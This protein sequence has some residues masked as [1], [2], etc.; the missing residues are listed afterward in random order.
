MIKKILKII[1]KKYMSDSKDINDY[2]KTKTALKT[3]KDR[4]RKYQKKVIPELLEQGQDASEEQELLEKC[5]DM[6]NT[7]TSDYA[8]SE[9]NLIANPKFF[10]IPRINMKGKKKKKNT[11]NVT[12]KKITNKKK[13]VPKST[14]NSSSRHSSPVIG[15][16]RRYNIDYSDDSDSGSVSSS[17]KG[18]RKGI[19]KGQLTAIQPR[20]QGHMLI[21]KSKSSSKSRSR[22]NSNS[23]SN[24]I[25]F[26]Y[27]PPKGRLEFMDSLDRAKFKLLSE[28][29]YESY[30]KEIKEKRNDQSKKLANIKN[31]LNKINK[32]MLKNK[33][34]HENLD[35]ERIK[36]L[37]EKAKIEFEIEQLKKEY[38]E[39]NVY[40]RVN[41]MD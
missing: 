27:M 10:K 3:L 12:N 23:I 31:Q 2:P 18:T 14:S 39:K 22:S 26:G 40:E 20:K 29:D 37:I 36:L 7:I 34:S 19:R 24:E 17:R 15:P 33:K 38:T 1:L 5:I 9:R 8:E 13:K 6:L 25:D 32:M 16:Q 21:S 28:F 4:I 11:G 41:I 30:I 35:K